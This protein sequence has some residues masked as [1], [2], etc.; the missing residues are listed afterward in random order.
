MV[1]L[2]VLDTRLPLVVASML[3]CSLLDW[4]IGS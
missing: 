2:S 1:H 4:G 3:Q